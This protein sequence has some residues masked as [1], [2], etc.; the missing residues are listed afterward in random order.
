MCSR[1]P[2]SAFAHGASP[3]W[4]QAA[5]PRPCCPPRAPPFRA[6]PQPPGLPRPRRRR[7]APPVQSAA[8]DGDWPTISP[9]ER[10]VVLVPR[11]WHNRTGEVLRRAS[12][13]VWVVERGYIFLR[14]IDV[15]GRT[16]LV[17]L[18]DGALFVHAPLALTSAL[19]QAIDR[20]G[21][22][23]VVVAPNT[24]HVDFVEQWRAF[25]PDAAYLGPPGALE[26]LPGVPFTAELSRDDAPHP[27]FEDAP[28]AQF[29]IPCAPFFNE[30]LFVHLPTKTLLCTDFFWAYPTGPDVPRPTLAWGW[31]MNNIYKP[32]YDRVLVKDRN[33]LLRI[34]RAVLDSGFDKIIPC[35][36]DIVERDG[37]NVLRDFFAKLLPEIASST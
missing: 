22:V 6:A 31:A 9:R 20:I 23:R 18:P 5:P 17:R 37:Q 8:A 15:G 32:V 36:G 14:A 24:E 29:F 21:P 12:P 19:K 16:T 10:R 7:G 3:L 27:A 2:A 1:F 26:R 35:H 30:T 28:L 33:D 4:P 25:Y 11:S 34:V 13:D